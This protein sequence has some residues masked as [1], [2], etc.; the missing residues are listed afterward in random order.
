MQLAATLVPTDARLAVTPVPTDVQLA[1]Y[2][3][4]RFVEWSKLDMNQMSLAASSLGYNENT[5]N[6]PGT[7]Y[8]ET[9][10]FRA[11]ASTGVSREKAL[12]E[13]GFNRPTW[14]CY[15]N[16]FAGKFLKYQLTVQL[17]S[18][19]FGSHQ[20]SDGIRLQPRRELLSKLLAGPLNYGEVAE[21]RNPS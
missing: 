2:P 4:V 12:E 8:L 10:S 6:I 7:A 20:D 14:D 11:I 19:S 1:V 9:L 13:L 15:I 21:H 18:V 17:I 5:W 16:H 3:D